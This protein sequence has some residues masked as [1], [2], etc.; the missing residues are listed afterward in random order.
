[1]RYQ[2]QSEAFREKLSN[3]FHCSQYRLLLDVKVLNLLQD[4]YQTAVLWLTSY[5]LSSGDCASIKWKS[6][7]INKAQYLLNQQI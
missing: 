5:T 7:W 6:A 1:M 4:F 3:W 2:E